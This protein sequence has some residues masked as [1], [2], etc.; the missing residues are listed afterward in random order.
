M[1]SNCK[2]RV[3]TNKRQPVVYT[4]FAL[5]PLVSLNAQQASRIPQSTQ[6]RLFFALT[7]SKHKTNNM[8]K[9]ISLF[10]LASLAFAAH[11]Q[12][13]KEAKVIDATTGQPVPG[14]TVQIS[15][16]RTAVADEKGLWQLTTEPKDTL[17][18]SSTGYET[19][20]TVAGNTTTFYLTPMTKTMD[21]VSV[22]TRRNG[23]IKTETPAPV[24]VIST[25]NMLTS[26][27]SDL[28]AMLN[29]AAPSLNYN[30]QSGSDGA[31][32]V[33]LATLRGLGPDQTLVLVNGKRRHQ[34]SFVAVFGTR[35]RGASGTDLNAIP[36]S[37][38]DRVEILRDGASAQYGSDAIAGVMNIILKKSTGKLTGTI[39]TS[40]Y[41]D[42]AFNTAFKPSLEQYETAGKLDGK[43]FTAGLNYG[44]ALG[45]KGGYLNLSADYLSS[46]KTVRQTLDTTDPVNNPRSMYINSYRRGFG[47]A[48]LQM[49]G[50]QYN[51]ELPLGNRN[52]RF[53]SFGGYNH[54]SSDAFAFTRNF[55]ARPERFPTDANGESIA[56]PGIIKQTPDGEI[57][58]TPHIQ[59]KIGDA[60]WSA[61]LKGKTASG[62]NWDFSNTIGYNRFQF[63]A[64]KTFN[65]SLGTEQTRFDAGGFSFFQNTAN[66]NFTKEV[67]GVGQGLNLA[68]GAEYRVEHYSIFKGE[69]A[70][71]KNYD[72]SGEKGSGSQGFV[73]YQPA[74]E[75]KASR[76]TIG[77]YADAE[78]DVTKRWLV[79]GAVRV[80]NY[81]DFGF[82]HNYK[83]A[84]RYKIADNFNVRGT[85]STG[86]RAPS[87]Q[88][89]NY[90]ST[91]TTV[92]GGLITE[93]KLAPNAS[94]ITRAA[95]IEKLRQEHS[96]N[97]GL[98]FTWKPIKNL[99]VAVD[100]YYVRIKDRV[101]LT[102][103]FDGADPDI[104]PALA[105]QMSS[106]NV[107]LAQFF[108]NAV[109]T[110][111]KGIDVVIDYSK[112]SGQHRYKVLFAG[113]LQTMSIDKINIP[114]P[115]AGSEFL[116]KT[117]YSQREQSF[118]LASAPNSKA[119]FNAEYGYKKLMIGNRF[120]YFGKQKLLGY[121]EDGLGIDP[122]VPS[123]ADGSV[124]V[125]DEFVYRA[126]ITTDLYASYQLSKKATLFVGAD[127][128]FNFHPSL[129]VANG[130]KGWAYNNEPA[131][132]W[133]TV[134]MN[135]N[136]RRL[137]TKILFQF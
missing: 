39:G 73:G 125:K 28:T 126:K 106:L 88:Q 81:S 15:S 137:F 27:H 78:L 86:F 74:D 20:K 17:T 120:T 130:A 84:T 76:S 62:W 32:H 101:V 29:Y 70:S 9:C 68:A 110:T 42:P 115:L 136:G 69:E 94:A 31:D 116:R 109:N 10:L 49:A 57:H 103:Q 40:A 46:G 83:L 63:F 121:G 26:G 1:P 87:L 56:Y 134:Q 50:T 33:D 79:S 14:A 59:T 60:S 13:K 132:P 18:I 22:G 122:Q 112:R 3:A 108:A 114:A 55:S 90:S 36:L 52:T 135:G 123:D 105:A 53:Y 93:I 44:F 65:A 23:R 77:A 51:M 113:N 19:V 96:L 91:F 100:G 47:D 16:G 102:G 67:K 117:F 85:A 35:G 97:A 133:D 34:T 2:R 131:G 5:Q 4:P 11:A 41:Y 6:F 7:Q 72:P 92:Q 89:I 45:K 119:A 12:T 118:L 104:D 61:G 58:Y 30:K 21:V 24:D 25:S 80:E 75:V 38:I 129:G 82:T 127:N 111:N 71:Y 98:G 54:R 95:G 128:L 124:Y 99:N 48:S 43:S 64:D 8:K 66:A 107:G 37:S